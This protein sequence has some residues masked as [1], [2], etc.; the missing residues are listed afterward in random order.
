MESYLIWLV[1]GLVLVAAEL[2]TG[3]FYLLVLGISALI[4]SALGYLGGG[5]ATQAICASVVAVIGVI[6]VYRWRSNRSE[7]ARGANNMDIGQI[8]VFESW[9]DENARLARVKYRGA[10]WDARL[11]G[12]DTV[13]ANETLYICGAEGSRLQVT[14]NKPA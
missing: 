7:V 5:F 8:V 6:V 4:G 3:T 2:A 10:S 9:T 1:C 13:R 12:S 14:A 11:Q